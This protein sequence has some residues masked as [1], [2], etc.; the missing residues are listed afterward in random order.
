MTARQLN[1]M[2]DRMQK[3]RI[4][5][6]QSHIEN[7]DTLEAK[8]ARVSLPASASDPTDQLITKIV[9]IFDDANCYVVVAHFCHD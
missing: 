1:I 4:S 7:A 8:V 2:A 3:Q 9:A 6:F 5:F